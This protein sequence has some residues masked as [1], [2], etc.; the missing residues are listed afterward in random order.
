MCHLDLMFGHI[1][2]QQD[3]QQVPIQQDETKEAGR[4]ISCILL[5]LSKYDEYVKKNIGELG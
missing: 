5:N 3:D 1:G 4:H 2:R